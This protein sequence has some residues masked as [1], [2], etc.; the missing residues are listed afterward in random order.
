MWDRPANDPNRTGLAHLFEHLF[1]LDSENLGPGGLDR[2]MNRIGARALPQAS[3]TAGSTNEDRTN[4]FEVVPIEALEKALWAEADKLGFFINTVTEAVLEK[5]K[6]VVKN[7]YRQRDF[8]A[9][10][11]HTDDVILRALFPDDHPYA[12]IASTS[13]AHVDATT[14]EHVRAFHECWYGPNNAELAVFGDIDVEQTKAWIERYFDEIPSRPIPDSV[15]PPVYRLEASRYLFH[16]DDFA[17]LPE[18]TITWPG[19]PLFHPDSYALGA[20]AEVLGNGK[21]TPLFA[22]IVADSQLAPGVSMT[23]VRSE[24]A[25]YMTLRIRAHAG[26]DLDDVLEAIEGAFDRFE[27]EGLSSADLARIQAGNEGKFYSGI[28]TVLGKAMQLTRYSLFG[29]ETDYLNE[30]L[31]RTLSVSTRD[32]M[33]VYDTY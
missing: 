13:L 23:T 6:Q 1:F 2:L 31:R 27:A 8:N 10:Y 29:P 21:A 17:Q 22:A 12:W 3:A 24:L 28:S 18:L 9:P 33:R 7:E 25:G 11:G 15:E 32:V 16:E 4:Y 19:V 26:T 30:D 5:E 20:L 14:L